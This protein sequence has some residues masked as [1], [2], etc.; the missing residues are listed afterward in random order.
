VIRPRGVGP[1]KRG[2]TPLELWV[3]IAILVAAVA[4]ILITLAIMWRG[5]QR[6]ESPFAASTE[7]SRL[8]PSCGMG[9]GWSERT[10]NTCGADLG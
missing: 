1:G 9:N 7:G 8:C 4:G 5:R 2:R 10:C 6:A 3:L